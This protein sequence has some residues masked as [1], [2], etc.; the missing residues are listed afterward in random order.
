IERK[1]FPQLAP[2]SRLLQRGVQLCQLRP[3]EALVVPFE[4]QF[5]QTVHNPS[6]LNLTFFCTQMASACRKRSNAF[7][8]AAVDC[9]TAAAILS[10]EQ[11]SSYLSVNNRLDF[12]G[13]ASTQEFNACCR[14]VARS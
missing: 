5:F 8:T 13:N 3:A 1:C 6:S 11:H 10:I 4:K 12:A 2:A 7:V 9:S 14:S